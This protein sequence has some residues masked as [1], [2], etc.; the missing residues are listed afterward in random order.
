MSTNNTAVA[1]IEFSLKTDEGLEF[2]RIW[3]HGDFDA[4]RKEWPECPKECFD[5][6]EIDIHGVKPGYVRQWSEEKGA[7]IHVEVNVIDQLKKAA[8]EKLNEAEKAWY[9]LA[10]EL[11]VGPGRTLAFEIYEKVRTA[12]RK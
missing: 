7:Y 1:A 3:Q 4:I 10:C 2:L 5:G 8:L 11:D 6:A 9:A 12:K